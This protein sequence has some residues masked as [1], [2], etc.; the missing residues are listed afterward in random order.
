MA[1]V[2]YSD[3]HDI[4][5]F[6]CYCMFRLALPNNTSITSQVLQ[7]I[8][9]VFL[10]I[11]GLVINIKLYNNLQHEKRNTPSGRKG[12]VVHLIITF[13]SVSQIIM[14]PLISLYI[15]ILQF[16]FI[17]S[18]WQLTWLCYF[19]KAVITTYR[20]YLAF[21]SFF[22][23]TTRYCFIIHETKVNNFGIEKT[24][25]VFLY[26]SV[27]VPV[28]LTLML[29]VTSASV[30][31][32][33]IPAYGQCIKSSYNGMSNITDRYDVDIPNE[34]YNLVL[35]NY[36]SNFLPSWLV[37]GIHWLIT[38][39]IVVGFLNIVEVFLY[40]RMFTHIRR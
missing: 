31:F 6:A 10:V 22:T 27:L 30:L 17:E 33:A 34:A 36:I 3:I 14:L 28:G 7:I 2:H 5:N 20:H 13:Y 38:I 37:D 26:A 32:K 11:A 12:N 1:S 39:V 35:Y 19:A 4:P 23:A 21:H 16:G 29:E 24:K 40:Q 15:T 18:S 25:K 9:T 8:A